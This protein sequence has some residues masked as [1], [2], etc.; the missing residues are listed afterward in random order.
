MRKLFFC[1]SLLI[2]I[3]CN[4]NDSPC[5]IEMRSTYVNFAI[6]IPINYPNN[7][8]YS[9]DSGLVI[10]YKDTLYSWSL[11]HLNYRIKIQLPPEEEVNDTLYLNWFNVPDIDTV[12][13][14]YKTY[15]G[16]GKEHLC[17]TF[18]HTHAWFNGEYSN[19]ITDTFYFKKK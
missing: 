3:D 7:N 1:L 16:N 5:M 19:R 8:L 12:V 18:E 9:M 6:D 10:T 17:E 2:F 14:K 15:K 11:N 4:K 13:V